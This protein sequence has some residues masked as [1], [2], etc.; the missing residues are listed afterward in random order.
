MLGRRA[1]GVEAE[2]GEVLVEELVVRELLFLLG[3]WPVLVV[4]ELLA[5]GI[6]ALRRQRPLALASRQRNPSLAGGIPG[7]VVVR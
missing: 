4:A 3:L 7:K 6:D 5:W 2:M 1:Q